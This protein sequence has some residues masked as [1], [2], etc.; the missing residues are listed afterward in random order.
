MK[1]ICNQCGKEYNARRS[2]SKYCSTDC[3]TKSRTKKVKTRC[4][5]CGEEIE[6]KLCHMNK[7]KHHFCNQECLAKW[8]S[9]NIKGENHPTYSKVK[10]KC[11]YCGKDIEISLCHIKRCEKH[12]CSTECQHKSLIGRKAS[13]EVKQKQRQNSPKGK[14]SPH[15][16]TD[17]TD[18]ERL[19]GRATPEDYQWRTSVLR[20]DNYTCQCCDK[21]GVYLNAHHLNGYHWDKEHRYDVNNGVTLCGDC[22][23]EFHSI[24]GS[25]DNTKEQYEQFINN[26]NKSA[27]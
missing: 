24:Y 8:R 26:K 12:Y 9:D 6:R 2:S 14:D 19:I 18:E 25:H 23:K 17:K 13:E 5:Y 22:H 15:W 10:T 11:T 21:H 27:S 7:S 4:A 20:R 1:K 3:Q 16:K